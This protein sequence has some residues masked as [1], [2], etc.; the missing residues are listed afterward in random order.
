MDYYT[1]EEV[2]SGT[3]TKVKELMYTVLDYRP[4]SGFLGTR[5]ME[6]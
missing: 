1:T 3:E 6:V 4:E 5:V 2:F